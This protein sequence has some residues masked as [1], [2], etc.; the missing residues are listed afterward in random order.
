[1]GSICCGAKTTTEFGL[2]RIE[3]RLRRT[4][5]FASNAQDADG[6]RA[7]AMVALAH[8]L[9]LNGSHS[10]GNAD[11]ALHCRFCLPRIKLIIESMVAA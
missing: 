3:Q 7:Q 2:A 1:V 6:G 11:R 5:I 9:L 8:R 10:A 4:R